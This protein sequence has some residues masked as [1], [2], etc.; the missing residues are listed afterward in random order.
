M[1]NWLK[2]FFVRPQG[3]SELDQWKQVASNMYE[4]IQMLEAANVLLNQRYNVEHFN[5][6]QDMAIL[7]SLSG[8]EAVISKEVVDAIAKFPGSTKIETKKDEDGTV[9][10]TL[11]MVE[12]TQE[13]AADAAK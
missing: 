13:Q 3:Q 2:G 5:H 4:R 6:V 8:G 1:F 12:E 7:L 10:V 11:V 9:T